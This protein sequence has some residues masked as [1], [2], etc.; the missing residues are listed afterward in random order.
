MGR[1]GCLQRVGLAGSTRPSVPGLDESP[2]LLENDPKALIYFGFSRLTNALLH[3]EE[4]LSKS[5]SEIY[6]RSGALIRVPHGL[7]NITPRAS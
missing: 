4:F 6:E 3:L 1:L 2:D 7:L 5:I